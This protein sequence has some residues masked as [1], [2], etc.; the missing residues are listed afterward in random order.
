MKSIESDC[1]GN[2]I[3]GVT[4]I[5]IIATIITG[6]I[7]LTTISYITEE[8][9]SSMASDDFKNIM[10]SYKSDLNDL[11]LESI[12]DLANQVIKSKSASKNSPK[13]IKEILNQKRN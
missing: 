12:K 10:N 8:N 6:I 4:A 3:T 9:S 11:L 5:L 7:L 2:I 13:D 1:N